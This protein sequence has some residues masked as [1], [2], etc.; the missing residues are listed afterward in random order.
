[1]YVCMYTIHPSIYI[2]VYQK[3]MSNRDVAKRRRQI[4]KQKKRGKYTRVERRWRRC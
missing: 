2:S 3:P 4:F 1:M